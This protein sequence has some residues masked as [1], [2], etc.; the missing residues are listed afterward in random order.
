MDGIERARADLA[1]GDARQA[2]DR[3]KALVVAYPRSLEIRQLL[4]EAYRRDGQ[5]AEAGRWGYLVAA[6]ASDAERATFERHNSWTRCSR[7]TEKRLRHLLRSEDLAS[8]ADE[9]GRRLLADL[10]HK[11]PSGRVDGPLEALRRWS[12]TLRA[13]LL[14][15]AARP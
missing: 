15:G 4:A 14:W 12:A 1:R 7:M 10:P 3:L 5:P 2:R 13:R 6:H 11:R 9:A 8:I